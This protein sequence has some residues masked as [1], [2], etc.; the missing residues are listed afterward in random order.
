MLCPGQGRRSHDECASYDI[1]PTA[2]DPSSCG[3]AIIASRHLHLGAS[4]THHFAEYGSNNPIFSSVIGD[5]RL[6][7]LATDGS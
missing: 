1:I 3:L 2:A 6:T 5:A 7:A 4:D